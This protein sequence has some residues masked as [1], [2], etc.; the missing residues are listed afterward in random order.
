VAQGTY[1]FKPK[2]AYQWGEPPQLNLPGNGY[3]QAEMTYT[4]PPFG[5]DIV[6]RLGAAASGTVQLVISDVAGDTLAKLNGPGAAGVHHVSWNFQSARPRTAAELSP[7]QRRD[8]ILL[9]ARAPMVLDSLQK[10]GYDTAAIRIVRGQVNFLSNPQ[11]LANAAG[12][13]RGGGGR[14]GAG[15]QA[16]EHPTTQWEQF[17]AR[18]AES[19]GGRRG[20]GGGGGGL[21]S[22]TAALFAPRNAPGGAAPAGGRGGRGGRNAQGATGDASLDPIGRIWALIGMNP[23]N[24]GGRGGGGG[25]GGGGFGGAGATMANTGDYLV[26][27]V[28]NGQTYKQTF[29]VER[30]SG[31]E[32]GAPQFGDEEKHDQ[33]G[34]YTPGASKSKK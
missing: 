6:Y 34:R 17:C 23:P 5:A 26:S 25:G 9:H 32:D 29:R 7:S 16:C 20:G 13:G 27:M 1:L 14:G 12:G 15:G 10:A 33:S 8:S 28:V 21:D 30:V 22:A 2:T 4:S 24:V 18:P 31:G 11:A 19:A 3:A